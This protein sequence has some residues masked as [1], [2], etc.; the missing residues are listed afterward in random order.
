MFRRRRAGQETAATGADAPAESLDA[1]D[2]L[3]ADDAATAGPGS[4]ARPFAGAD[5]AAGPWDVTEVD[6]PA[7]GGRINLGGIWL[8]GQPG[9][10]LRVEVDQDTQQLAAIAVIIGAAA[11]QVQPFAA[12]RNQG[13][14]N[15]IREEIAA[16]VLGQGGQAVDAD[17]PFGTEL[18]AL[19][20]VALPDG[21]PGAQAVRFLG[22]DGPRWF[23]R[24][25]ISG[26]AYDDAAAA[27]PL[28]AVFRDI[29]VVRGS[30][31]MA[32]REPIGLRLPEQPGAGEGWAGGDPVGLAGGDAD[33]HAP[34]DA[35][36]SADDLDP[37]TRG[38]EIT[39]IR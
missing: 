36:R 20:P 29:V 38:P 12:P 16:G 35:D 15:G 1:P 17:G 32:P 26:A 23:L 31:A 28:E 25:V 6:D 18:H 5:R 11:L 37:F 34:P 30:E 3:D 13:Q 27:T 21:T 22:V 10:E 4:G 7:A 14:W 9:M 39:E 2:D 24:G 8:P 33:G 19:V